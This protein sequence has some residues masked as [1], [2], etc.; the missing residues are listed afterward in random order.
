VAPRAAVTGATR[1]GSVAPVPRIARS[2]RA[3][4]AVVSLTLLASCADDGGRSVTTTAA[5]EYEPVSGRVVVVGDSLTVGAEEN[6]RRLAELHGFTLE[7]S[8]ASGRQIPAGVEELRRLD[9]PSAELV[10]VAL[11]T[12]DAAQPEFERALADERIDQALAVTGGAPVAWVNVYRDPGTPAGDAARVFNQALLDAG[13]RHA[14]LSALDWAWYVRTHPEVM[15]DDR[16][17]HTWEGYV[18]RS[19]W[20]RDE[21][22]ARLRGPAAPIATSTS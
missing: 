16:V 4:V 10:V 9:A 21:I 11:G 5:T 17:H 18:A 14:T 20:L 12:N 19:R 6:L 7:L 13:S 22:V 2:L 8:A 15:A 1:V 3:G